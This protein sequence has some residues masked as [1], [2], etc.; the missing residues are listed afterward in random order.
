MGVLKWAVQALAGIVGLVMT[1][2]GI[3][4]KVQAQPQGPEL[5]GYALWIWGIGIVIAVLVLVIGQLWWALWKCQQK[6]PRVR[7]VAP[8]PGREIRLDVHTYGADA[9]YS[10][11][12]DVQMKIKGAG[13]STVSM[14]VLRNFTLPWLEHGEANFPIN[15]D[16]VKHL[17]L[18][19]YVRDTTDGTRH[20]M[21]FFRYT[22]DEVEQIE[23][24]TMHGEQP[25]AVVDVNI[26]ITAR[27]HL[28]GRRE[29]D[30]KLNYIQ[31]YPTGL[32]LIEKPRVRLW[33]RLPWRSA[34]ASL[35]ETDSNGE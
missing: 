9:V 17:R 3:K 16:D 18:C 23:F 20:S 34:S 1:A 24:A 13:K 5:F 22:A 19:E 30:F 10:A 25:T 31:P 28:K 6:Q 32:G 8:Y 35:S 14:P 12:A 27:P 15:R 26:R 2:V 21:A 33:D 7:V 4:D 29:W 11:V